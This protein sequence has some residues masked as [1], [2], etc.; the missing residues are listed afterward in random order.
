MNEKIH[1]LRIW[2][3]SHKMSQ[4]ALSQI[5][6][7]HEVVLS[8]LINGKG[9]PDLNTLSTIYMATPGLDMNSVIKFQIACAHKN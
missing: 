4:R 5:T 7:V 9:N 3:L 1:P 2:L 8:R 6:G